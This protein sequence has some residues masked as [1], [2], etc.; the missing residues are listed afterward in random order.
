VIILA[1]TVVGVVAVALLYWAQPICIPFALAVYFAFLLAPPVSALQRRGVARSMAVLLVV[2]ATMSV[3]GA[4]VWIVGVQAKSL[5]GE[6]PQFTQNIKMKVESLRELGGGAGSQRLAKMIQEITGGTDAPPPT[7]EDRLPDGT[8]TAPQPPAKVV[9]QPDI[10][11]WLSGLPAMLARLAEGLGVLGMAVVLLF[12]ILLNREDLRNRLVRLL[13]DGRITAT[14]RAFN[15]ASRRISRYLL[16]QLIINGLFGLT[17]AVGLLAIGVEYAL[18]WGFLGFLLRYVPYLGS[19]IAALLP[20]LLSLAMFEGWLQPLLVLALFL[21][22]E[23]IAGNVIEP[24]LYGHSIGVSEVALLL[25]AAFW[26]F[27]W[28]PIGLVLSSPLTVCLLVLGKH[29]SHLKF[30]DVLLGDEPVLPPAVIYYQRLLARDQDEAT[31][32]VWTQLK[33]ASLER[34]DDELI[35][36]ALNYV[37]QGRDRGD[38]TDADQQFML[39]ATE[40]ILEEL[41]DDPDAGSL[42]AAAD[43]AAATEPKCRILACPARD[44]ADWLALTMLR[45]LLDPGKWDLEISPVAALT[46]ELIAQVA[47]QR[48]RLICIGALPPGG[49][50]HTRYLCKRLRARFPELKIVVG[51]W[52][53]NSDLDANRHQL[54]EAG[55]DVV[56]TSLGET[57]SH[58]TSLLPMLRSATPTSASAPAVGIDE[59]ALLAGT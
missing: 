2:L 46:S 37:K 20:L 44:T 34:V 11:P 3:L 17:I 27:L 48:P 39:Q 47:Q 28:G 59:P 38:L 52:G 12:F 22:I 24:R 41:A 5:L 26:A 18:L 13:G 53:L 43:V 14:T 31:D 33:T 9:V 35:V 4:M 54:Q 7:K 40:E 49:L 25:A 57:R 23:L 55:A 50:A 29:V 45:Q 58:L 32:I 36:P 1:G 8:P 51:R 10:P 30:L 56:T 42:H 19:W 6:L 16:M 21:V 15:D